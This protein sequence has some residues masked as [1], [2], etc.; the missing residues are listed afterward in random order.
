VSAF[1][2][3]VNNY[4]SFTL[5]GGSEEEIMDRLDAVPV[6]YVTAGNGLTRINVNQAATITVMRI[7]GI[8]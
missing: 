6:M 2:V 8:S 4:L 3:T 1:R 7:G 5:D